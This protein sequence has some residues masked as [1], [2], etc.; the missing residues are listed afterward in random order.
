M[1]RPNSRG[2]YGEISRPGFRWETYLARYDTVL[3]QS[4]AGRKAIAK[5]DPFAFALIYFRH[6][7]TGS[8]AKGITFSPFHAASYEWFLTWRGEQ[9]PMTN[10]H[11]WVAARGSA[12][13]T[14]HFRIGPLWA[15]AF[16]HKD[17][18]AIFTRTSDLSR[19]HMKAIQQELRTNAL[20]RLD[21]PELCNPR[22]SNGKALHDDLSAY[23]AQSG[24]IITARGMDSS[25]LGSSIDS[26]RADV[27]ILDD[28]E[29]SEANYSPY[30]AEQRKKTIT[31][32]IG[33]Y[34]V[35]AVWSWVGTTTMYGGLTHQ[36]VRS[37][38]DNPMD[39]NDPDLEWIKEQRIVA[40]HYRPLVDGVSTWP[41]RWS[42]EHL[43]SI[44][45]TRMYRM[46]MDNMPNL[47]D[48]G[49]W[50]DEDFTYVAVADPDQHRCALFVDPAVT[51]TETSDYSGI[52]I[53]SYPFPTHEQMRMN[54]PGRV[55]VLYSGKVK[56][57]GRALRNHL[58]TLLT[59]FPQVKRVVVEDNQGAALW[60]EVFE[61]LPVEVEL[62]HAVA[63]KE[64]RAAHALAKYQA[65]PTQ[66]EHVG[67]FHELEGT[68]QAFPLVAHDDDLDAAV[69]GV[70]YWL[71]P[72]EV[73]RPGAGK[74]GGTVASTSSYA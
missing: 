12:K 56:K 40:H 32:A 38:S 23:M 36:L 58:V 26:R 42:T 21:F 43:L 19:D 35:N 7:L 69:Y 53:T 46:E 45:H 15:C 25:V 34:N 71:S 28:V 50:Q 41:G 2:D 10:R 62:I 57:T 54:E 55:Q 60:V 1:P 59:K 31:G 48:E 22:T 39:V 65:K 61:E 51:A 16:L 9:G 73:R 30:Q 13:S 8:G 67:R 66:V 74:A 68:M 18:F 29:N 17:Y 20:L 49:M 70:L 52:A 33:F 5:H 63:K 44:S 4:T 47:G 64:V 37:I 72:A 11:A 27:I 24:A 3:L 14:L 6:W